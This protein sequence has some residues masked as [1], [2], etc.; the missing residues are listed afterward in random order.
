MSANSRKNRN[1]TADP[2]ANGEPVN[3]VE[4]FLNAEQGEQGGIQADNLNGTPLVLSGVDTT[5]VQPATAKPARTPAKRENFNPDNEQDNLSAIGFVRGDGGNWYTVPNEQG[6]F[7]ALE[8]V[9]QNGRYYLISYAKP[10]GS[11]I[12]RPL[13]RTEFNPFFYPR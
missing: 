5:A 2:S 1:A 8:R 11:P 12:P 9:V 10:A 13:F 4:S 6:A 3:R 7:F